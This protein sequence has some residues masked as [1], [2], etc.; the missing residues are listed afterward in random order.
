[1]PED[2]KPKSSPNQFDSAIDSTRTVA[3]WLIG[4]YA[5]VGAALLTG[6]QLTGLGKL[7]GGGLALAVAGVVVAIAGVLLAILA[8]ARVLTPV[9]TD[10]NSLTAN[11]DVAARLVG[12]PLLRSYATDAP[13]LIVQYESKLSAYHAA[14]GAPDAET[15]GSAANK[16]ALEVQRK[17]LAIEAVVNDALRFATWHK[18]DRAFAAAKVA[19]T[20]GGALALAGMLT[21]AH[22]ANREDP[23][24]PGTADATPTKLVAISFNADQQPAWKPILGESCDLTKVPALIVST[25]KENTEVELVSLPTKSGCEAK[26][27]KIGKGSAATLGPTDV[28]V[29]RDLKTPGK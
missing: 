14:W 9:M 25:D 23:F 4:A 12:A 3:K 22:L 26:H 7:E 28:S 29:P 5:A 21:F 11:P 27:F 17:Y 13:N 24:S 6:L 19:I 20:V 10:V 15:K 16:D 1:M 8:C 2:D 18:V